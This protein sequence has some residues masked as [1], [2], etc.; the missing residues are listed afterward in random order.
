MKLFATEMITL[1]G[2]YQGPGGPDEDRSGGFDRGGW[3]GLHAD[4]AMGPYLVDMLE[5]ADALLLG[6]KTFEIWEQY[7]PSHDD[8]PIGHRINAV[9]RYVPSASRTETPWENT[10]FIAGD[11]ERKVRE[12]KARPGGE[13]Q[14]HGSGALLRWLLAHDLVDELNLRITPVILGDGMR[15][16]PEAGVATDLE[17]VE[18]Q[19]L[20]SGAIIQTFR[21]TGRPTLG[22]NGEA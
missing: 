11:L 20:P 16:F 5:R 2:V 4:E 14:V 1:D 13:L 18:S 6:R 12:L 22:G 7:W 15:L 3:A 19:S 21:P 10:H 17:L 9:P 8:N